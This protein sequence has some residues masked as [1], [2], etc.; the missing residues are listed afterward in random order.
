MI[1]N[2]H[3]PK[4]GLALVCLILISCSAY[5]ITDS[6]DFERITEEL[7]FGTNSLLNKYDNCNLLALDLDFDKAREFY[8]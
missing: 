3:F 8:T 1:F 5:S 4:K 7:K 2:Q 6:L